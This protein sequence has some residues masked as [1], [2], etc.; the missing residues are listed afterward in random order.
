MMKYKF[1]TI[2]ALALIVNSG[3]FTTVAKADEWN[4][5]TNITINQAIQVQDTILQP[6]SYVLKLVDLAT[7]RYL[8]EILDQAGD[9]VITAVFTVPTFRNE[10]TGD[11]QF[12]FYAS[13]SAAVP[14][15]HTWFYPGD[16]YGFEF[17]PG[18]R[19][20]VADAASQVRA[21]KLSGTPA[22]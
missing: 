12:N 16:L 6:G 19:G 22:N 17:R 18:R 11:S 3:V 2:A 13:E 7:E 21:P 1:P 14:E 5:K 10:P 15:L 9:R 8:V 20:P 4:K